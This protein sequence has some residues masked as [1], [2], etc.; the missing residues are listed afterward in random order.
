MAILL[1]FLGHWFLSLFFQSFFLH[2]YASHRMFTM[3]PFWERLFYLATFIVQGASFINPRA[4]AI[5]HRDHHTHSDTELDPHSPGRHKTVFG[6]MGETYRIYRGIMAQP[7]GSGDQFSRTAPR[8][9]GFDEFADHWSVRV[10]FMLGYTALYIVFAPSPWFFLLLPIHFVMGP[11]HGAIVNWCG[12]KYGYVN[13]RETNDQSRNSLPIDFLAMGELFQNN[14]HRY[15][16][17]PNFALKKFEFDPTYPILL[18]LNAARII[19][20]R[21]TGASA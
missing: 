8:W 19:R 11:V 17:R 1:F 5:M 9:P 10:L 15:P 16:R 3:S 13:F 4:Y 18:L 7:P 20:L 14:H 2:R 21:R 6:M 12:H